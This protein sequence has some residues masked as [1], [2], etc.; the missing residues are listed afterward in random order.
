MIVAVILHVL[1]NASICATTTSKP[2]Y[3]RAIRDKLRTYAYYVHVSYYVHV[4]SASIL[5]FAAESACDTLVYTPAEW[6]KKSKHRYLEVA[7]NGKDF[8]WGQCYTIH[9]R[10]RKWIQNAVDLL[11]FTWNRW[12]LWWVC[13]EHA[14]FYL[15]LRNDGIRL[16]KIYFLECF[17]LSISNCL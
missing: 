11:W 10:N 9:K 6:F 17:F 8:P 15:I 16:E 14:K 2:L 5:V 7:Q 1:P 12:F 3:I 13:G 4:D